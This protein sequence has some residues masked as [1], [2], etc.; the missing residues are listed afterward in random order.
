MAWAF[1]VGM[2][3]KAPTSITRSANSSTS[4]F[5]F[6]KRTIVYHP[7]SLSIS[8][9][10]Q[11]FDYIRFIVFAQDSRPYAAYDPAGR[12]EH[13]LGQDMPFVHIDEVTVSG[14]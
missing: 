4:V 3:V 7:L 9:V 12:N 13:R 6:L 2:I 11:R 14:A 5:R 1:C 10:L 8:K